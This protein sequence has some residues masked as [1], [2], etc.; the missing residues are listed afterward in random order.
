MAKNRSVIE[1]KNTQT[2]I[3]NPKNMMREVVVM[4][5]FGYGHPLARFWIPH[6]TDDKYELKCS[7]I[8]KNR[9]RNDFGISCNGSRLMGGV[10]PYVT[11]IEKRMES[12]IVV[13]NS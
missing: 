13:D 5:D 12:E 4:S 7:E 6:H 2:W 9:L 8:I 11:Y 1:H 3:G 10:S